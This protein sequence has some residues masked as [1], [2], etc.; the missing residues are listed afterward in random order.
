MQQTDEKIIQTV[1]KWLQNVVIGLNL[2]PF[3]KHPYQLNRVHLTTSHAKT[4]QELLTDLATQAC[5]LLAMPISERETTVL[6]VSDFLQDFL[7]YNQFLDLADWLLEENGWQEDLQIASFHPDYQFAGTHPQDAQNLTN[8]SP[9]PL[10]HLI[11][12]DSIE[13]A[14]QH[15]PDS[16]ES[17][18]ETNIETVE[19]LTDKDKQQLFPF[20]KADN[21]TK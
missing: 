13:K 20:L 16:P 12:Q 17:I 1:D 7:D 19:N 18:F 8:R 3:A 15:F 6:I 5:E 4:E 2:C 10:L 14:L 9:F 21:P 11:R